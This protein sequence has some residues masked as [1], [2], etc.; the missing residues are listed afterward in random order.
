MK[1]KILSLLTAF[2]MVFGIIAAPFTTASADNAN[3]PSSAKTT[4]TVTL[5]KILMTKENLNFKGKKVTITTGTGDKATVE[6]KV[7]IEKDS[8]YYSTKDLNT[9]IAETDDFVKAYK[10]DAIS[11]GKTAVVKEVKFEGQIGIDGTDYI[12]ET[13]GDANALKAYFGDGSQEIAGVYFVLEFADGHK[14][15]I[16]SE[17]TKYTDGQTVTAEPADIK[18]GSY[19]KAKGTT[20]VDKLTPLTVKKGDDTYLVATSNIDDAVGGLTEAN[21]IVFKTSNLK[22][23]FKIDEVHDK[24]TYK[25][26]VYF[27]SN[28]N[29]LVKK[30]NEYYLN[31]KTAT[32]DTSKTKKLN[33]LT[34]M[35][36]VPVEIT[37][38]LVNAKGVVADA[39]VYPKNIENKPE[40]D[41]NFGKQN[42]LKEEK[43]DNFDK[44]TETAEGKNPVVGPKEGAKYENYSKEK[45]LVTTEIGKIVPYEVKTKI[46]A[47]S[48]LKTAYWTDEMTKG[49]TFDQKSV[50]IKIGNVVAEKAD[51][52]LDTHENGFMLRLTE[53]GLAKV[54]DKDEDVEV[55]ITYSAKVN[56]NVEPDK[57]D[58]NKVVFNYGNNPSKG[59]T[60]QENNP[61]NGEL[62][63][64]KTWDD[65]TW[66]PGEEATFV[67]I[68]SATGL[69]VTADDLVKPANMD[70][71]DWEKAKA[72]FKNEVV[73][74]YNKNGGEYTWKYLDNSKKYKAVETKISSGSE[75]EYSIP[76]AGEQLVP[77]EI[78]VKNH[79]SDNPTPLEP[80]TPE[81]V[82]GGK[83]FVKTDED[84]K[85]RLA[86]AEFYVTKNVNGAVKY[87]VSAKKD[88]NAVKAAKAELDKL[89]GEYNKMTAEQQKSTDGTNKKNAINKAQE[90][91][92][93]AFL[94]NATAYTWGDK[95]D[96]NVVV[97]TSD[98]SGKLEISGLEYG[99][100]NLE[101]KTPPT[102]YAK[103]NDKPEF[104]VTKGSYK[105]TAQEFKYEETLETGKEQT[106]GTQII[107]K[108]VT[109]PQ[110]GGIGSLIF[111]VAGLAIMAGAFV[112]Y[113]K[114]QAVE[115]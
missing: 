25:G 99:T 31:G 30:G 72:E 3:E 28:G 56:G 50:V 62:K 13:L 1:K 82:T 87:L 104:T 88:A 89:I 70:D 115:A 12:G 43:K 57:T 98:G 29:Q 51:Y 79:K 76:T 55:E 80:T 20:G 54:N 23:N 24:S 114:S 9:A 105:S 95:T 52:T 97:L 103:R 75:A 66:A 60:P 85:N 4:D 2:A 90:D 102:G 100:Y 44:S 14:G 96:A 33:V 111:I 6:S 19:V 65:G 16:E 64:T 71:T 91:F 10:G 15:Y 84:G 113:K 69:K 49:L 36:A 58:K 112:A 86:G 92:N 101:E 39:H 81:V 106:Y 73:I 93:K 67:L 78:K 47:K 7:I 109:I 40:I 83:K 48:K 5:H 37:L 108:K 41:K 59:N 35:R 94:A 63:V 22:G 26:E 46:P 32:V 38:P 21:G 34:D 53:A 27:D 110:T 61:K 77:G 68:D 11:D 107:N 42:D 17:G 74:G 8:K 45:S 18:P